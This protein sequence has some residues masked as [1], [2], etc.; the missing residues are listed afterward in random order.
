M[1]YDIAGLRIS[2]ENKSKYT[3]FFCKA[4]LSD[5]QETPAEI[6]AAVSKEEF[7]EEKSASDVFRTDILKIFVYIAA[8]V[9]SY[10]C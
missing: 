4:Y 10:P 1:I 7:L 5:D 8:F 2:I 3:D 9:G 6:V